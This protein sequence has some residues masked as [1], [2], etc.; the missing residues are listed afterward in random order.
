MTRQTGKLATGC[1]V[2]ALALFAGS[3]SARESLGVFGG[4]GAFADAREGRCYAISQGQPDPRAR[5]RQPYMTVATWPRADVR[6]QVFWQLA[7]TPLPSQ[8]V[9]AQAAGKSFRLRAEGARVWAQD[10]AM[11]AA[12]RAAMR[13]AQTLTVFYRDSRGRRF[14]DRYRLA[15]APTALDAATLACAGR[16]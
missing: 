8:P 10:A 3:A 15:G 14:Y 7:R 11:D 9:T 6:G 4:W 12:I 5:E 1:G 2:M 13:T 16:R